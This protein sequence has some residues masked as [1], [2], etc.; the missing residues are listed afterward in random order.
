[1]S[2]ITWKI[3]ELVEEKMQMMMKLQQLNCTVCYKTKASP[4]HCA[5]SSGAGPS[6]DGHFEAAHIVS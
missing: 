2:S 6:L 3:K 1:M 4:S 5:Q